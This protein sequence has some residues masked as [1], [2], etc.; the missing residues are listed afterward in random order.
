MDVVTGCGPWVVD[1]FFIVIYN[2]VSLLLLCLC[3]LAASYL[4]QSIFVNCFSFLFLLLFVETSHM[5][6]ILAEI[7]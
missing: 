7:A 3:F 2:E 5:V 6:Y 1:I 4:L